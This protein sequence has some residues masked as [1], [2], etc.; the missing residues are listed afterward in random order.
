[1]GVQRC[2]DFGFT[3]KT[4]ETLAIE[5]EGVRQYLNCDSPFQVGVGRAIYLAHATNADLGGDFVRAESGAG[6]QS[7]AIRLEL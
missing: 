2:E 6:S 5:R 1:L 7:H 4:G 3:L